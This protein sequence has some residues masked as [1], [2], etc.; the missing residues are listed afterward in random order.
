MVAE[1][2]TAPAG[3]DQWKRMLLAIASERSQTG[4]QLFSEE[5]Q[6]EV[7]ELLE[8]NLGDLG[9]YIRARGDSRRNYIDGDPQDWS[10]RKTLGF[11]KQAAQLM[12]AELKDVQRVDPHAHELRT[13]LKKFRVARSGLIPP[14]TEVGGRFQGLTKSWAKRLDALPLEAMEWREVLQGVWIEVGLC[15][16]TIR[17]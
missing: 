15:D 1:G 9:A 2:F 10:T 13:L 12:A 7:E 8:G 3:F 16:H 17:S 6:D 14:H 4:E 11:F 5:I